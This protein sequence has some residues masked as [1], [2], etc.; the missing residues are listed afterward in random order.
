ME[1]EREFI[2]RRVF[3][4]D[5]QMRSAIFLDRFQ[6]GSA[7]LNRSMTFSSRKAFLFFRSDEGNFLLEL[8]KNSSSTRRERHLSL[9]IGALVAPFYLI[10]ASVRR[11]RRRRPRSM[12]CL[13][14]W[15]DSIDDQHVPLIERC[16]SHFESSQR[17]DVR[18]GVDL[19][20]NLRSICSEHRQVRAFTRWQCL[21]VASSQS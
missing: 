14:V 19:R 15:F 16:Q 18:L 13:F 4:I 20:T 8:S 17:R 6:R 11:C 2:D 9:V 10:I 1:T 7:G 21:G 12:R 5:H 3:A